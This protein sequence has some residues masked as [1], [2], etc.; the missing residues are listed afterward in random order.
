MKLNRLMRTRQPISFRPELEAL[1]S[2][3]CPSANI[4]VFG[5][6]MV[7]LGDSNA[8]A[9]TVSDDGNGGITADITSPT[10]G[11]S[12][13]ATGIRNVAIATFGGDDTVNYTQSAA[14]TGRL[15]LFVDLGAGNDTANL[16][17]TPGVSSSS[18]IAAV[19]G[20]QGNDTIASQVGAIAAGANAG[21]FLDGGAGDDAITAG[22]SGALNGRLAVALSGDAGNDTLTGNIDVADGSTGKLAAL[23]NGGGGDDNLTLNVTGAGASTLN[24]LFALI[25]GG[26]GIDTATHTANVRVINTEK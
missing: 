4:F 19:Y 23:V 14:R 15:G 25:N 17:F 16:D 24:S 10:G 5:H 26:P 7:I 11:A 8:N 1:E 18:L 20:G 2:R 21:L 22:F 12:R 13:T 6:T 9:V 3:D